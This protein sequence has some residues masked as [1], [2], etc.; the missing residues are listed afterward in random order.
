MNEVLLS[1]TDVSL[2]RGAGRKVLDI[3]AFTVRRGEL[4]ALVGPNGAGK[5]TLLQV[6]NLL[7]PHRGAISLFGEDADRADKTALRRRCAL[8][9]QE[10]LL[11][12]DTVF[13]NVA[14][15]LKFRSVNPAG[16]AA[17]VRRALADFRCNHL[18]QRRVRT[19]S[20][21]EAQRVSIARA[22]ATDPELLL[23]DEPFA[24]LDPATRSGMIGEL[25]QLAENRGM[26]V[27]L[28]SHSFADVLYFAE[29]AVVM[30][31]GRIVQD[32]TPETVLRRPADEQVA[33]LVGM[34]NIIP[35][36]LERDGEAAYI[37]LINGLRFPYAG[38][39]DRPVSAC[40]LPGDA[41]RLWDDRLAAAPVP[42]VVIEGRI[43]RLLPG[44]GAGK[45]L[46]NA[47]D[48]TLSAQVPRG[49]ILAD[50]PGEPVK[51]AFD[52]A[53]AHIV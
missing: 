20:G 53:E 16:I 7:H 36:R 51:L 52:P 29:R 49:Y 26:T 4:V 42:W 14:W 21:G 34:D 22:L 46:V 3:A 35:C 37:R 48:I 47:G 50:G 10:A 40:C 39:E 13:A 12:D 44:V 18:E 43:Q 6:A 27:I 8:L 5:S 30:F 33:R 15:P 28:V 38:T 9:F 1:L 17:R 45:L 24:A 25:R 19:L 2:E 41:L 23:L 31:A 11:L 32:D